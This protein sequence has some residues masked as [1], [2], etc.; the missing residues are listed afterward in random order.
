MYLPRIKNPNLFIWLMLGILT[1]S[2]AQT[3]KNVVPESL[4]IRAVAISQAIKIDGKLDD[5]VWQT[6][7][8]NAFFTQFEPEANQAPSEATE[9]RMLYDRHNLYVGV[10]CFDRASDQIVATEMRRD[11]DLEKNDFVALIF[12]TFHDHR[13][14]FF[15]TVNALG[16]RADGLITDE[17]RDVNDD[18]N[19]VWRCATHIDSLGW[20]A[21]VVLPFRTLRFHAAAEQTWG[22]NLYR[23]IRRKNEF[24]SWTPLSRDYGFAA[25]FKI[26]CFGHITGLQGLEQKNTLQFKPYSLGK[27]ERDYQTPHTRGSGALGVDLKYGLAA[28]L[29]ADLTV[30]TDFAQVEVDEVQVNLSRFS[31][32]FPEKRD[33]FLEGAGTF[34]FGE[35]AS[36]PGDFMSPTILFFSRRIGLAEET[37]LPILGGLKLTGK[38]GNYGLG[39][40][41]MQVRPK[42]VVDTGDTLVVPATNFTAFRLKRDVLEKSNIGLIFL[43]KEVALDADLQHRISTR[44]HTYLSEDYVH[45][46]NRVLGVDANLALLKNINTGGY[47]AKSFTPGLVGRDWSYL[48][49][50]KWDNDLWHASLRHLNIDDNFN[51]EMGFMPREDI[52]K[53]QLNLGFSPRPGIPFIRQT[54]FFADNFWFHNQQKTLIS[55]DNMLGIFNQLNNG[56]YVLSGYDW[57]FE[58][59]VDRDEFEIRD[60]KFILPGLYHSQTLILE[61][62]SDRSRKIAVEFN[63]MRA[64]FYGGKLTS[65]RGEVAFTATRHLSV[66][67][68]LELNFVT[69]LAVLD[70]ATQQNQVIDFN[71]TLVR[72]RLSYSF[73]PDLYARTL[74]QWN[75]D[76]AEMSA[77]FLF[78]WIYRP[79]CDF[80]LVYHEFWEKFAQLQARDR[81]LVLKLSHLLQL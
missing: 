19:G 25:P 68:Q 14:G 58:R 45:R 71:T 23:L 33:F 38:V 61:A 22:F 2:W 20:F 57:N 79:G 67:T 50:F 49:Y 41:N 29:I 70:W 5:P 30:N 3:W 16:A 81:R 77:N 13:N 24:I 55:R 12:D 28:N 80:Y 76:D 26:S 66:E 11:G 40:L 75:S 69:D 63:L 36:G 62:E 4:Q 35:P 73:S 37:A 17:G 52:K 44:P 18:W 53:S 10:A 51:P 32:F 56:G 46:F 43:N 1:E 9:L 65:W 39:L 6:A 60:G 48:G 7:I 59:V 31:L 78:N 47:V 34:Y 74:I 27:V 8:P 42:D 21:E 54:Y 15:F 72:T 64:G